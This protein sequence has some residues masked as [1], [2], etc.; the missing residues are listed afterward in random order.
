[1]RIED[2]QPP[3][4][5]SVADLAGRVGRGLAIVSRTGCHFATLKEEP[6]R[7]GP[8]ASPNGPGR[9]DERRRLHCRGVRFLLCPEPDGLLIEKCFL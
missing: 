2:S 3:R 1:M 6:L 9:M 4:P 8:S 7:P 5:I